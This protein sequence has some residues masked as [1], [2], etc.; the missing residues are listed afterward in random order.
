MEQVEERIGLIGAGTT[1]YVTY[2]TDSYSFDYVAQTTGGEFTPQAIREFLMKTYKIS[3]DQDLDFAFVTGDWNFYHITRIR[4]DE[5][6]FAAILLS[7]ESKGRILF[8][9]YEKTKPSKKNQKP[10]K[11]GLKP[12]RPEVYQFNG[13]TRFRGNLVLY[14]GPDYW[15]LLIVWAAGFFTS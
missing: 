13:S 5:P 11:N 4:D 1:Y 15:F 2:P 9:R 14:S 6:N 10:E 7:P 12:I 8:S 3:P